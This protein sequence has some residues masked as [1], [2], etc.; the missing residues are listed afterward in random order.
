[1][2]ESTSSKKGAI[3][4]LSQVA[5]EKRNSNCDIYIQSLRKLFPVA[6]LLC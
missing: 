5:K 3:P 6:A 1:M 2:K 4:N